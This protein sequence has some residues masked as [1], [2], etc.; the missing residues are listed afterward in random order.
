MHLKITT[1]KALSPLFQITVFRDFWRDYGNL[2]VA[3]DSNVS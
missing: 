2:N 1:Q 3:I